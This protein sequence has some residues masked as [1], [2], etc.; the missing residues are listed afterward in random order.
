MVSDQKCS[1]GTESG[2]EAS[3]PSAQHLTGTAV[4][5]LYSEGMNPVGID[6]GATVTTKSVPS[7]RFS[8]GQKNVKV[9]CA[10]PGSDAVGRSRV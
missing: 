3:L 2:S 6:Q 5:C 4:S 1:L 8:S 9:A 7:Q 10:P